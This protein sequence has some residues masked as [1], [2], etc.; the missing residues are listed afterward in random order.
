MSTDLAVRLE[1]RASAFFACWG[2][3][4]DDMVD[5]FHAELAPDCDW[6]QRPMIRTRTRD[7][8]ITFLKLAHHALALEYVDVEL[9]SIAVVGNTVHPQRIA[10]LERADGSL[11]ASAPVAGVLTY[12]G[13]QIVAWKEYFDPITFAAKATVSS[14]IWA[15]SKVLRLAR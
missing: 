9:L 10:H 5:G 4:F 11:I 2:T 15:G 12:D 14:A 3:T 6:D 13:D 7:R 8:A 1:I